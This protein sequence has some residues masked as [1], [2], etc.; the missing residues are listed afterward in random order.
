MNTYRSTHTHISLRITCFHVVILLTWTQE[1]KRNPLHVQER[2][3]ADCAVNRIPRT[4]TH[5]QHSEK[6]HSGSIQSASLINTSQS[7][8]SATQATLYHESATTSDHS[9]WPE[10]KTT[11][12]NLIREKHILKDVGHFST[13]KQLNIQHYPP[14]PPPP[15][16]HN[17]FSFINKDI[18]IYILNENKLN[19]LKLELVSCK[20]TEINKVSYCI[21]SLVS[22]G[23]LLGHLLWLTG[24][25]VQL[26]W[27]SILLDGYT[28]LS[29][30]W[31]PLCEAL[32]GRRPKRVKTID[33]TV[34]LHRAGTLP[35]DIN[36]AFYLSSFL[37]L[38]SLL[39]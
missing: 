37:Q 6:L 7:A 39:F 18:Y 35:N 26:N 17:N 23:R 30:P 11:V 14:P 24:K 33:S 28:N 34:R 36:I 38:V 10:R 32:L 15:P 19:N 29:L 5:K 25:C 16:P 21:A 1:H 20:L 2:L 31:Q 13:L 27:S 22:V 12:G 4:P 9:L 8:A 3:A